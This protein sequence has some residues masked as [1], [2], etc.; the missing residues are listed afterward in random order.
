MTENKCPVCGEPPI[1][2]CRCFRADSKCKNGHE[3]H[4]CTIHD[5]LVMGSSDHSTPTMS[6][7]CLDVQYPE[8][9]K[10][11]AVQKD[12]QTIG[13]FLEYLSDRGISL[14]SWGVDEWNDHHFSPIHKSVEKILAEYFDID[15]NKIG[16][17]KQAI[18]D[19][20]RSKRM[21]IG[22]KLD[23]IL[24]LTKVKL[25]VALEAKDFKAASE[26]WSDLVHLRHEIDAAL[27]IHQGAAFGVQQIIG[28]GNDENWQKNNMEEYTK[29][30]AKQ[31]YAWKKIYDAFPSLD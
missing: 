19:G 17:E 10:M 25:E 2:T 15:L 31:S 24:R 30:C 18:L 16:K 4:R 22:D 3:W 11:K 1:S 23:R 13:E 28:H 6:C 9:E 21:S 14:G 27:E 29:D 12:S 7:T 20:I 5:T 26:V 8:L